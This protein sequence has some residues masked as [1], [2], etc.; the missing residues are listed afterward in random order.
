MLA[1]PTIFI[2]GITASYLRDFYPVPPEYIWTLL[3]KDYRRISLHPADLRYEM[4][5]P[6]VVRSDQV[7]EVAYEEFIEEL[8]EELSDINNKEV[9]V[10]PFSYD[11]RQPLEETQQLLAEFIQEVLDRTR[12]IPH[13]KKA[14]GSDLKV[15]LIGHSM[16]GLVISRCL[17]D[18]PAGLPV[19]KVV[20]LA[21][22]FQGSFEAVV[23]LTVGTGNLGK[24]KPSHAERRS[25]RVTPAL[26]QLLPTFS[27]GVDIDPSF[28][29]NF[30]D[31]RSWQPSVLDS[32]TR[33]VRETGANAKDSRLLAAEVFDKLLAGTK[34]NKEKVAAL[35]LG[36]HGLTDR[37]WLAVVGVDSETRI[38]QTV[39]NE[40]GRPRYEFD[41]K[42]DVKNEW[43]DE[44]P[45]QNWRQTGDGTVPFE[46]AVPPFLSE[47][48]L[49]LISPD[50]Y[51][52]WEAAD[53]ALTKF[54]G[55]HGI[56]P[57][58]NMVQ[59]MVIRFLTNGSNRYGNT[60]GRAVP[61]IEKWNPPL[62]LK[63]K[64][65]W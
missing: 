13:Y 28:P 43:V 42:V 19:N 59:R 16:G 29:Q 22:P 17:T 23:K 40:R 58:M 1:Y 60:W 2:P 18:Q 57:N 25:A 49:V 33:Y 11:W 21:T 14:F 30:H 61:Y 46:G 24:G 51:G 20:T 63:Q 53:K 6:A 52:F 45:S 15:N 9:P 3:K 47:D 34:S 39:K 35:D 62:S 4:Q 55:F 32:I 41:H 7:F 48:Q 26:Y 27:A 36:D 5:Q 38:H 50:D 56:L 8:R 64:N 37:D 44:A 12:L 10:Y 65:S 54:G 31:S